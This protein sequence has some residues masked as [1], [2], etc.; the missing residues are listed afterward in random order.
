[1]DL[2]NLKSSLLEI[3][4]Y[5]VHAFKSFTK[6]KNKYTINNEFTECSCKSYEFC[7][8]RE[9]TCKHLQYFKKNKDS[10][11][12]KT[13]EPNKPIKIK[14]E[15]PYYYSFKSF[16]DSKKKY[17]LNKDLT[18]CSC[19]YFTING[20]TCKHVEYFTQTTTFSAPFLTKI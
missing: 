4:N 7:K 5:K 17:F 8:L 12:L 6:R 3:E 20:N 19:P 16:N 14:I 13:V 15:N 1:M 2:N 18:K 11:L 10:D 9:K